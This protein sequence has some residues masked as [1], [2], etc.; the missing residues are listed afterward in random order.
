MRSK[1]RHTKVN[2][3]GLFTTNTKTGCPSWSI[4]NRS[5]TG[6][7]GCNI[8][9]ECYGKKGRFGIDSVQNAMNKRYEWFENTKEN[10]I[11]DTILAEIEFF[12]EEYFRVH[13]NGDF[14]NVRSIRIWEKICKKL[15]NVKFW[16]PT[17]AYRV[18]TMLPYIQNLNKLPNVVVRP[19]S[20]DF[21]VPAPNIKGLAKGATAYKEKKAQK[22][23]FECPG[24]CNDCRIC[25]DKNVR[26]TYHYH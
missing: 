15:P 16:F 10:E 11:V 4:S 18:K 26:V 23:H 14:K 5:C 12:G 20:A 17:K 21:D 6:A 7:K 13:V 8:C 25:W 19:S 24:N 2:G 9:K 22:G 3:V 1:Y